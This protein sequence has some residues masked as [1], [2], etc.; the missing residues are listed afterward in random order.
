MAFTV[1]GREYY[2]DIRPLVS[3]ITNCVSGRVKG[4]LAGSA[5]SHTLHFSSG[6]TLKYTPA[7]NEILPFAPLGVTFASGTSYAL[8]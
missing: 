3:G 7:A 8:L 6:N 5:V 1:G 4:I 2:S